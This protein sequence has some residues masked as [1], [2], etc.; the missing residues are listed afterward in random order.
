ML[1]SIV[2]IHLHDEKYFQVVFPCPGPRLELSALLVC[3]SSFSRGH[4]SLPPRIPSSM[5][6]HTVFSM[7]IF[8]TLTSHHKI[9]SPSDC[10]C[11]LPCGDSR[12]SRSREPNKT[13]TRQLRVVSFISWKVDGLLQTA[14]LISGLQVLFV[15]FTIT[16][17]R[18]SVSRVRG[19]AVDC[20][21]ISLTKQLKPDVL[22]PGVI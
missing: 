13:S 12:A 19:F 3:H 14:S 1:L 8:S 21:I 16:S 2:A 10:V 15:R 11:V 17:S 18:Y 6:S 22:C 20:P 5:L 9:I 7:T 4:Q